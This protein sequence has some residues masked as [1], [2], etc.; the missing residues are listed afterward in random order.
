MKSL[1]K[2]K[3]DRLTMIAVGTVVILIALWF[4]LMGVQRK[5]LATTLSQTTEREDQVAN[6][7]RLI[8]GTQEI[9][10]NLQAATE[11]LR[12]IEKTMASGDMY[13]WVIL[14]INRF[15][16]GHKVEIP[17]FSRE[18]PTEIGLAK[19][20]YRAVVFHVRGTAYY[21]D[22]GKFV[23]E[24][25]NRFPYMRVQNLELEPFFNP[26]S[27]ESAGAGNDDPEKLGFRMQIV[28]LVNPNG[29]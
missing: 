3:R 9:E 15:K 26:N 21:H 6:A 23:S 22:L 10:K 24:F 5:S 27:P 20:P 8:G 4:G 28:A 7:D 2:E 17:H 25:E 16:E 29:S 14:T 18:A 13:S 11:R 19:F 1:S 12:A